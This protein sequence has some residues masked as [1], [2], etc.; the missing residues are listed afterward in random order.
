MAGSRER[1]AVTEAFDEIFTNKEAAPDVLGRVVAN[2]RRKSGRGQEPAPD[3]EVVVPA[4]GGAEVSR[5]EPEPAG[6]EAYPLTSKP[7]SQQAYTEPDAAAAVIDP[8]PATE[9]TPA[10]G[11]PKTARAKP[12]PGKP[13]AAPGDQVNQRVTQATQMAKSSTVTV[14]LRMPHQLNSWLDAYVHESW[15]ERVK[16]QDL[17]AEALRMLVARRGKAGEFIIPTEL[18]PED[19]P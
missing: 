2:D 9:P 8:T 3:P 10:P 17:I 16:K 11:L 12:T 6:N 4:G 5:Q 19:E 7:V 18:L 14:S 13:S 15:P 1:R